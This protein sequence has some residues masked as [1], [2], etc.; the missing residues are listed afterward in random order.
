MTLQVFPGKM[1]PD[2]DSYLIKKSF[3]GLDK[4]GLKGKSGYEERLNEE[5]DVIIECGLSDFILNTAYTV[6]LCKSQGILI[7]P[8]RGS[9]GGSLVA[10]CVGITEIDPLKYDLSFS[11]FLNKAR[12]HT[13][14]ADIDIDIPKKDRPYV[15][16]L[17][18]EKFGEEKTIQIINDVYFTE[19]TTIKDIG[20]IFGIDFK[21]LNK[22]TALIGDNE[23]VYDIPE[24]VDFF[25]AHPKIEEAYPKIKGLIRHSSTHA[26]GL[27]ISDKPITDYISTLKVGQNIVTCYNGRTC[28]ALSFL[29]QDMLG[30]NTLSIIKDT[31]NL[32]GKTKFD[33]DYDLDDSSVY[34]TINKS[35]LG[36]F[37]LEGPGATEYT[38]KLQPS[39]FD[40]LVADLALVRPGAQDSGDAD[41]FLRVRFDG[42]PLEYDH[43]SLESVLKETNGCILYQEQAMAISKVLSGFTDVEADTLRKGIGKKLD[44]IFTEYKPKFINGAIQ[45]GVEEDVAE[46][47]WNKIEKASSYSFNKSH[48]VGYALISYQT[49]YLK[50]YYPIEYYLSLLNNTD[51][52]DKRIKIYSEIRSIDKEIVNPDINI[53][54]EITTSDNDKI[55]L[56][57]PLIK[58]VGEKA[59]EKILEG[60]PYSSY[61]DFC[62]RCRVNRSVKKALIQAGAFDCFGENRNLLYNAASGETD[63][64]S[65]KEVLFREFQVLK[66]NPRGNVLDLYDPE[67]MGITKTLSSIGEIKENTEDYSDFYVKAIVSEFNKKDDYAHLSITDGFDSMSIYVVNEFVSRYIDELNVIGNCLLLHLHG[68][69]EKY[70]LLSCIN[71]EAPDKR[72]H[73]YEF[74]IDRSKEK[75]KL[76]QESNEHINVGLVS[77]V[78][79]FV[80]KAGNSC[81][82]YNVFVD[83]ETILEDRIVCNEDTLMVDGSYIFFYMQDNPTFLDIRRV[84]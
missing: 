65:D 33:F 34:K 53:S 26:G 61:E 35:T 9:V 2:S 19:K 20:R 69:G 41:E 68:K 16:K 76:L 3:E 5:L 37:Q 71:L 29:K 12:M 8:G 14:L 22:L 59:V 64:W 83:N 44:Y 75:L 49:A 31:L 11:R 24:I 70:S 63:V 84:G 36:I 66:I 79:P 46:L 40:D 81:R 62:N 50:T 42:K 74:Y 18:K 47:V 23:D 67:K 78:R 45:N 27:L 17:L 7:G 6:L 51:D 60:Q 82:W 39:C 32:I 58:G 28:D 1:L 52:E 77:N 54:K 57:F 4:K 25:R 55:Y 48:A 73:E 21:L 43:P 80:S 30:L 72:A 15:L 56:S 13:S 38:Q 10:Y